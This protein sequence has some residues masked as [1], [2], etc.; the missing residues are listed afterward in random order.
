MHD[1]RDKRSTAGRPSILVRGA[2]LFLPVTDGEVTGETCARK[3]R[4]PTGKH[5]KTGTVYFASYHTTHGKVYIIT[6][7]DRSATTIL[8]ANEY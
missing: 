7:A 4:M 2:Q 6:E 5:W 3:T 8:F 1:C